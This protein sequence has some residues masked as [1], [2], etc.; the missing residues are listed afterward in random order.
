MIATQ[1]KGTMF[2]DT[3]DEPENDKI[4]ERLTF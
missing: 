2:S 4:V 3:H 1:G